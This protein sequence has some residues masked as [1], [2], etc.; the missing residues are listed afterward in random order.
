MS[1]EKSELLA[2][3]YTNTAYNGTIPFQLVNLIQLFYDDW[4]YW[5]F[6]NTKLKQFV[7]TKYNEKIICP[8]SVIFKGIEF[9]IQCFPNGCQDEKWNGSVVFTL[10]IKRMP[11]N[12]ESFQ[13]Y[14]EIK[15]E[16]LSCLYKQLFAVKT[17]NSVYGAIVCQCSELKDLKC[18][19]FDLLINIHYVT[20][21]KDCNKINYCLPINKIQKYSQFTWNI[22]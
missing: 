17:S 1:E 16:P 7:N 5:V 10:Q 11:T 20:Y 14:S 12:I 21:K 2:L 4:I 3:G 13:F 6:K 22:D 8:K 15:C 18:I 19:C 9:E